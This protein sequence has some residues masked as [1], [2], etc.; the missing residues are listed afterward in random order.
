MSAV[1][2]SISNLAQSSPQE[3]SDLVLQLEDPEMRSRAADSLIYRWAQ[4][5]VNAALEWVLEYPKTEPNRGWLLES[6][7][8]TMVESDP[9]RAI[10][11]AAQQPTPEGRNIGIEAKL[12]AALAFRDVDSAIEFLPLARKGETTAAANRSIGVSLVANGEPERALSLAQ[13][14]PDDA[15]DSFYRSISYEWAK[16]DPAA[17]LAALKDFPTAEIR[18]N[19]ASELS[20]M[21]VQNFTINQLEALKQYVIES[22][23]NEHSQRN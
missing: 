11:I 19:V 7:L 22:E 12:L 5:N 2:Q 1:S 20:R 15:K 16:F 4:D 13:Q 23:S 18:S 14:L 17:V 3:A 10:Q 8:S 9:Q 6:V 21:H